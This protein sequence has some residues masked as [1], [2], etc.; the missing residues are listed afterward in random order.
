MTLIVL[1][2]TLYGSA[3]VA[4]SLRAGQFGPRGARRRLLVV[5][6]NTAI[7]ELSTPL[8]RMPGFGAL[9][10]EFDAV[11][12]WNR[13]IEPNHP[14]AWAPRAEDTVVWRSMLRQAWELDDGPV[15]IVCESLH[16][17]PARALTEIFADSPVHVYADG[18]MSYGP[19]R[20]KIPPGTG[21]RVA[22]LLHLDVV[23][24]LRP[25]LLREYGVEPVAVPDAEFTRVLSE[26]GAADAGALERAVA[27]GDRPTAVLLG[28]YLS[29]L[30][31]ITQAEET[32]LYERMVR[33]AVAAG[34]TSLLFK[35]HP[36]APAH[37]AHTLAATARG[38]G[39]RLT[40]LTAPMLAETV[41]ER[42]RPELVV[43]CFSTALA[44][45]SSLYG[46]PVARVGTDCLLYTFDAADEEDSVDIGVSRIRERSIG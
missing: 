44:T 22:R 30:R 4:A 28:Q 8:D 10:G 41:F 13:L 11:H 19:T 37:L 2:S 39:A 26:T 16:V 43:G 31:L 12:S 9:R 7:P 27:G 36:S 21:S 5:S 17:N 33:A 42:L 3:T 45:A 1:A 20:E 34:H 35:P 23:P 18:L 25:L 46:I 14:A 32:D 40:V 24:G 38:L 15:E 29:A 6:N